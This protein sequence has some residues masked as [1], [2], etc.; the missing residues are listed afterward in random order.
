MSSF[1]PWVQVSRGKVELN[2]RELVDGDGAA[3]VNEKQ[4][5]FKAGEGGEFLLFDLG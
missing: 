5:E 3:V 1:P 4:L 2:G